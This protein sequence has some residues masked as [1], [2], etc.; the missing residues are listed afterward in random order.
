MW[1]RFEFSFLQFRRRTGENHRKENLNS[2]IFVKRRRHK[3]PGN[4]SEDLLLY[5]VSGN[6]RHPKT[7]VEDSIPIQELESQG[8]QKSP[9]SKWLSSEP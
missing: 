7:E 1:V 6:C 4:K 3:V 2:S 9:W 5:V 8:H